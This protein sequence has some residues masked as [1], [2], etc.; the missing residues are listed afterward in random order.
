MAGKAEFIQQERAP[1]GFQLA[2]AA[3]NQFS[4]KTLGASTPSVPCTP[5]LAVTFSAEQ[6]SEGFWHRS[7]SHP[8]FSGMSKMTIPALLVLDKY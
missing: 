4:V 7:R 5:V 6:T 3:L 2:P 1:Q 8:D